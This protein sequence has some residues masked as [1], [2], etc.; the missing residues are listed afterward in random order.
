MK[1]SDLELNFSRFLCSIIRV[2]SRSGNLLRKS[3]LLNY[4]MNARQ[5]FVRWSGFTEPVSSHQSRSCRAFL[6]SGGIPM[7]NYSIQDPVG[8]FTSKTLGL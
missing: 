6:F 4:I 7:K 2:K 3:V 5:G 1:Y 8:I